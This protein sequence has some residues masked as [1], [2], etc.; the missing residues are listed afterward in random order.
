MSG[1]DT[2]AKLVLASAS[3]RRRQ[4]LSDLGWAFGTC[5]PDVDEA[6]LAGEVPADTAGRLACAKATAASRSTAGAVTIGADTVVDVDGLA[7][8]KPRDRDDACRMLRL[9]NDRAHLV[10]TGVAV[11]R[12]GLLLDRGVETTTVW[13][14]ALREEEIMRFVASGEGD[15]KAGAYAIQGLGAALVRRIEGCYYNV[16]G[17]PVYRLCGMLKRIYGIS[18]GGWEMKADAQNLG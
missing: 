9:L 11:A 14:G 15:D 13:F 6:V 18:Y 17:L 12:D 1:I 8:G 4:I 16:V 3:P 7:L 5:V 10:H 2:K